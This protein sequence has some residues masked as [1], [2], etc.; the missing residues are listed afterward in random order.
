MCV[1][2]RLCRKATTKW[3]YHRALSREMIRRSFETTEISWWKWRLQYPT[4]SFVSSPAT[5]TWRRWWLAGTI[6]ALLISSSGI[7]CSLSRPK[8]RRKRAW[9]WSTTSRWTFVSH[10]SFPPFFNI[11]LIWS[12]LVIMDEVPSFFPSLE[13]KFRR[14]LILIITLDGIYFLTSFCLKTL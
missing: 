2:C 8:M 14:E 11:L 12:R 3:P 9:L 13:E 10:Y 7:N 6:R 5:C 4:A 1:F